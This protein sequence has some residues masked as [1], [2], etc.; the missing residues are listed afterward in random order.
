M[1]RLSPY[2]SQLRALEARGRARRLQGRAGI[3]FSSNDYLGLSRDP[4]IA[5]AVSEA[6]ARGVPVGSGGSRLLR[7][8]HRRLATGKVMALAVNVE[9]PGPRLRRTQVLNMSAALGERDG[10]EQLAREPV[11]RRDAAVTVRDAHFGNRTGGEGRTRRHHDRRKRK[12]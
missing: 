5:R 2:F 7:G 10:I 1:N 8:N 9:S 12:K 11:R 3:D 4:A 6:V